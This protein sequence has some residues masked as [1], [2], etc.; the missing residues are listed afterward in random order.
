MNSAGD[1]NAQMSFGCG[2]II[3]IVLQMVR[4]TVSRR[5]SSV[6]GRP[7][8]KMGFQVRASGRVASRRRARAGEYGY[9]EG[10]KW[11]GYCFSQED[12]EDVWKI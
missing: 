4:I 8:P 2:R 9:K 7:N 6:E 10:E 11:Q 1:Q 12:K 3:V 5:E